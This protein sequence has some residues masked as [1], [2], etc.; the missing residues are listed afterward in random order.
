MAVHESTHVSPSE[1]LLL[2]KEAPPFRNGGAAPGE[3]RE[4][5]L[6]RELRADLLDSHAWGPI[7]QA[8]SRTVRVAVALTDAQGRILGP[9]QNPQPVW[10]FVRDA[11]PPLDGGCPFCLPPSVGCT[12]VADAL[13]AREA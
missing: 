2:R 8:Y 9:C 13:Q 12:A 10:T 3:Y 4:M 5:T 11:L 6:S 1:R 7:L